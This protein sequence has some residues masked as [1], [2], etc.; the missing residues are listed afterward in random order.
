MKA[1]GE[2]LYTKVSD[3]MMVTVVLD[4]HE[5]A[6]ILLIHIKSSAIK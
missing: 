4:M 3:W 6:H 5:C 1:G 2:D